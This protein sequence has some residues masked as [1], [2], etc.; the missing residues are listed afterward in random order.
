MQHFMNNK[1]NF[2]F[3]KNKQPKRDACLAAGVRKLVQRAHV[4][5]VVNDMQTYY[6]WFSL[7][8]GMEARC[9][10][11]FVDDLSRD[12]YKQM[13]RAFLERTKI[14]EDMEDKERTSLVES[15]THSKEI[16]KAKLFECYYTA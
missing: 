4:V 2:R 13:T 14:D 3:D 5:L 9:D 7:Y 8:P 16:V 10:V 6:E 12:G 1:E 11:M 15:I